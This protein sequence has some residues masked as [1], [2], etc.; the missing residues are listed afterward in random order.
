MQFYRNFPGLC[1]SV[2]LQI[3]LNLFQE[4]CVFA[5]LLDLRSFY[6][7]ALRS[8]IIF[9]DSIST[10]LY[11]QFLESVYTYYASTVYQASSLS[12]FLANIQ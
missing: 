8:I 3:S 11:L 2:T 12:L 5:D 10:L 1:N 6:N 4:F 7:T 9:Q